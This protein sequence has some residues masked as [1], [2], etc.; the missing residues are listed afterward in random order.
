MSTSCRRSP[1]NPLSPMRVRRRFLGEFAIFF[2]PASARLPEATLGRADRTASSPRASSSVWSHACRS[3]LTLMGPAPLRRGDYLERGPFRFELIEDSRRT[4]FHE[5]DRSNV[6]SR[7]LRTANGTTHMRTNTSPGRPCASWRTDDQA[8]CDKLGPVSCETGTI[9]D[10]P[11]I[12]KTS[13]RMD[14]RS[15]RTCRGGVFCGAYHMTSGLC[16]Q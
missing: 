7:T 1:C 3:R 16:R 8:S 15:A 12:I 13:R 5:A 14:A 4:V 10:V 9:G 6:V 2:V 11:G